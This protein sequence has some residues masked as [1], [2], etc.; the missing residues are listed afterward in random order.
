[1]S[2]IRFPTSINDN[3]CPAQRAV[4]DPKNQYKQTA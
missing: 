4:R 3:D 2:I 1:M